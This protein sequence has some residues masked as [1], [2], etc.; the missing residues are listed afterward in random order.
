[1]DVRGRRRSEQSRVA[2]FA[3]TRELALERGYDKLTIEAIA[4]RAGV[5][6][7]TIYR[8]WPSRPALVA[9]VLLEDF[10]AMRITVPHT[11]DLRADLTVWARGLAKS[12]TKG[13]F[14]ASLRVLTVS[15]LEDT[16]VAARLRTTF[17]GPLHAAVQT[18][19]LAEGGV[20]QIV[21][22]AAADAIIGGIVYPILSEG[23]AYQTERA[24]SV[25]RMVL[26]G[27]ATDLRSVT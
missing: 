22:R 24:D 1:M 12:L 19:L 15:A 8:W 20:D 16:D 14:S 23:P 3:A 4:A 26:T 9:D 18:R 17:S 2:I 13:D 5:G 10:G 11:D 25:T 27:L 21:A 7:Q 6:K